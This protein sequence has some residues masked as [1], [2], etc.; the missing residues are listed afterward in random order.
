[1]TT[2]VENSQDQVKAY[3][4]NNGVFPVPPEVKADND[5]QAAKAEP[6][7]VKEE[8]KVDKPEPE[9]VKETKDEDLDDVEGEDGL[10]PRQKRDF[11]K[12][13]QK[14]IAKKH[15]AQKEAEEFAAAQYNQHKLAEQRAAELAAKVAALEAQLKPQEPKDDLKEPSRD[16]FKTDQEYWDAMVDF[17][18][19]K[20]L[21]IAQAAQ[22]K[23]EQERYQQEVIAHAQAKV[24][25][26]MELV[27]DF[28][29]V[30][31]AADT[32]SPTWVM[33]AIQSSELFPELWYHFAKNQE[34]LE[35]IAKLTDGLKP[36]TPQFV[37][38]AQR[39]LVEI[40]KI[41]STLS[42]FASK[43]K[44]DVEKDAPEASQTALKPSPE[45]GSSPSKPR[46]VAPIIRP[47]NGG[48]APQV[49]K[50]EADMSTPESII[51]WQKKH[52]VKLTARKRH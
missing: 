43:A 9:V 52:G 31:E 15:R 6:K 4:E 2:V 8:A 5:A 10:T 45:T 33:E 40:G 30:T 1:M 17:R 7:V 36:G 37:K 12:S 14:T 11:T 34:K 19:D 29:D 48:S 18:V 38:A 39:Q 23:A 20:K 46:N 47:L 28:K 24:D 25:R 35:N 16:S 32:V 27:P 21:R 3:S 22:A 13:M 51:A 42:P 50:D 49:E 26:A 44:V 41:E